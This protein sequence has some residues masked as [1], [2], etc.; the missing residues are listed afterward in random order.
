MLMRSIEENKME[1]ECCGV[2]REWL[3]FQM[4]PLEKAT[5]KKVEFK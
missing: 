3:Y 4:A 1:K 2:C 5:P